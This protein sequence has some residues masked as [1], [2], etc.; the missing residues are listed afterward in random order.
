MESHITI[1]GTVER[2]IFENQAHGFVIFAC[3]VENQSIIVKGNLP[4]IHVGQELELGGAWI[5]HPKFGKQFDAQ[6]CVQK[7][8]STISGLKKYLG[9]GLIKGIGK[10][11]AEKIV[12]RFGADTLEIIDKHPERLRA[13]DGIGDKRIGVIQEAWKDQKEIASIMVFLQDKGIS[14]TYAAKIYKQYKHN[15]LAQLH[16]NPYKIADD[17]W[18]IGF[19]YADQIATNVGFAYNAPQRIQAGILYTLSQATGSGH[20]YSELEELKKKTSELLALTPQDASL[21]KTGLTDLYRERKI[22]VVTDKDVH[23]VGSAI[24]YNSEQYVAKR[25]LELQKHPTRLQ[26]NLQ[27]QYNMLRAPQAGSVVLNEDQQRG[28]MSALQHKVTI[29]TGGPGT[30]KTT[31]IKQFLEI[32]DEQRVRYKLAAPTGRAAK[33]MFEGTGRSALTVHRLLEFDASTM[34]FTH[35]EKNALDLD[36]LIVDESSMIDIFLAQAIIKSLPLDAHLVLIGDC[37][38]LPSVGPGNFLNDCIASKKIP[39]V[40]LTEIFR[41]AR[42]S[43]IIVNAHKINKGEFPA[44]FLPD[45]RKDYVFLKEEDPQ[46]IVNHIKR[47]IQQELK[48][49]KLSIDDL[50]IL[51][52][53]NRGAAGTHT[54]N[55]LLQELLNPGQKPALTTAYGQLKEGD[56]VMQIRNNYDKMVFNGDIGTITMVDGEE[57]KVTIEFNDRPL[58]YEYDELSEIVLAYAITIHKSQGSE[59]GAVIIPV[60]M[61]HFMLLQR[62]LLYTAI[63]RAKKLCIFIGQPK[64][65]ALAIKNESGIKRIS[66][67][68]RFIHEQ[69]TC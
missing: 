38:Q 24:H 36:Y 26:F 3:S 33:R 29:I 48:S 8:P 35:D 41:Q 60:F 49:H 44:S 25:L 18:G 19:K 58:E 54:L 55:M 15:A 11:Y 16:E 53:M 67:L 4:Q 32:L 66:F 2:I 27:A 51:V 13:I 62:N 12:D 31:L 46:A 69:T 56:K 39:V 64:A 65:I 45:A 6:H 17:I 10:V 9:S 23:Y 47:V 43:L 28:I 1:S 5:V 68:A 52:P 42:D 59:Y 34:R 21:L 20:L 14:P 61:Q 22:V 63:T 37:D 50:Q 30:G 57:K 7:I 40:K